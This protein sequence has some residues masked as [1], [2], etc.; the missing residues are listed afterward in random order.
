MTRGTQS[1]KN[2]NGERGPASGA[3]DYLR[4]ALS[5][6]P[7]YGGSRAKLAVTSEPIDAES[8]GLGVMNRNTEPFIGVGL[9]QTIVG[10]TQRYYRSPD[11]CV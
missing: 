6:I 8:E 7:L 9:R 11:N 3:R 1:G 2:R 10:D 4:E 5:S